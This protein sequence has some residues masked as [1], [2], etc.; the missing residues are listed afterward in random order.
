VVGRARPGRLDASGGVLSLFFAF[1]LSLS[2]YLSLSLLT[3]VLGSI[4]VIA[5]V[6]LR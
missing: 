4:I 2:L 6:M 3:S 5:C 1:S